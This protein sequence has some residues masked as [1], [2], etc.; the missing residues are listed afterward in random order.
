MGRN[1]INKNGKRVMG[2]G[3]KGGRQGVKGKGRESTSM[4]YS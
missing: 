4:E 2:N 1:A 3:V